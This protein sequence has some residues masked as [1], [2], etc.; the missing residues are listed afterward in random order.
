M[1][2]VLKREEIDDIHKW[3]LEHIYQNEKDWINAQQEA[4]SILKE[5]ETKIESSVKSAKNLLEF[6][7]LSN[8]LDFIIEKVFVY[9]Y[10]KGDEDTKDPKRQELSQR[11][12]SLELFVS[13]IESAFHSEFLTLNEKTLENFYDEEPQL[14]F[15]KKSFEK[16]LRYKPHTLT[17]DQ[18]YIMSQTSLLNSS[19]QIFKKLNNADLTFSKIIDEKGEEVEL[20][21][22]NFIQYMES[23]DRSVR[24]QAFKAIY[25]KFKEFKNTFA[26]TLYGSHQAKLFYSK[27]RKHSS[28]LEAS[29]FSDNVSLDV[30]DNLIDTVHSNIKPMED[31]LNL[32]KK[33]LNV[34]ELHMYD[35]F[36]PLVKD[37]DVKITYEEAY[38]TMKRAL[39]VLGEEY[40]DKLNEAY[41]G[42]W[43]DVYE[44]EGKRSGAY[45][46]GPYGV[47]PY[48]LLNHKDNLN[49]MFT[50]VHEMGHAMHSYFSDKHNS[51]TYAG[52]TIFVAEVASTVNEV[53]LMKHLLKNTDDKKMKIYLINYFLDQFRTTLYRQTMFAEF[54]KIT[55]Q[56]VADNEP[57]TAEVLS[58]IYYDLN[59]KYY[60]TGIVLDKEIA[61]EWARIPHFYTAF[62]VYKYATG[63]SAAISLAAQILEEG[64]P[65]VKRY[66]D[67]LKSGGTDYPIELLKR[68]GVDMSTPKPI[69]DAL[70][71]FQEL[72]KELEELTK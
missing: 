51:Q 33:M 30:Y 22:S 39:S 45:Q 42:G 26:E 16:T 46:S 7:E 27:M 34:D 56:R 11:L 63:F 28:S 66:L 15:Y 13:K 12:T 54:E 23:K 49:S 38:D 60:G 36:A 29:L 35:L 20:T 41:D 65:A 31:Y 70:T 59:K 17:K 47:H 61:M 14:L 48:V 44:N 37:L 71:V 1:S 62:Y 18:E 19:S 6:I 5:M 43:I 69:Q 8:R 40:I 55:H 72:V 9:A 32:R 3:K 57:L 21:Q 24:K 10:L 50:L 58:N 2:K 64:E 4:Q 25:A 67:F 52:Y 68:A 53:L